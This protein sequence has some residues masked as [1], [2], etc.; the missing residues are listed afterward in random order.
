MHKTV[1]L[2]SQVMLLLVTLVLTALPVSAGSE[3]Q[4]MSSADTIFVK[5]LVRSVTAADNTLT[6]RPNKGQRITVTVDPLTEFK[7]FY[8]LE[9]LQKRQIIE[10]WYRPGPSGN[11]AIKI[12]RPLELGC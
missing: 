10:V 11:M 5:G 4:G 9:E 3:E 12:V 2:L 6:I 7:G 1:S 8:K